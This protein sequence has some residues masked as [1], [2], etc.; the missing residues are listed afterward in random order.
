MDC[1]VVIGENLGYY[2]GEAVLLT[3]TAPGVETLDWDRSLCIVDG[4]HECSGRLGCQVDPKMAE[5]WN[6]TAQERF[7]AAQREAKR[8]A[9]KALRR[10][11]SKLRISKLCSWWELQKRGVL[12][13]HVVLPTETAEE[14]YWS[15]AYVEAW[16]ELAARY[17]F[18]FVDGWE[19]ISREPLSASQLGRYCAGY[20]FAGKEK[21]SLEEA[22]QDKRLPARTFHVSRKLTSQTKITMRNARLN[23]RMVAAH[24]GLCSWPSLSAEQLRDVLRYQLREFPYEQRE[25][26]AGWLYE[27]LPLEARG[28]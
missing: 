6:E 12:H 7:T 25:A 3:V 18:G 14:R 28:P 8:R 20:A 10:L 4:P 15:R 11:G 9:D 27:A 23:R 13:P 16:R 5:V 2:G 21:V 17:W 1:Y 26:A 19:K 22:V 24:R